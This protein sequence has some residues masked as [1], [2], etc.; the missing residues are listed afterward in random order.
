MTKEYKLYI[1]GEFRDALA[2]GKIAVR[3]PGT[4]EDFAEVA[5][6][7]REDARQ[8]VEAA[9][10]AYPGW[11]SLTVYEREGY[12]RKIAALMRERADSIGEALSREMGKPVAE[13]KGEV[14]GAAATIEWSAEVAK[15]YYGENIP[16]H[17]A[18]KRLVTLRSPV[19][20]TAAIAPWNF[21][22]MLMARKLGPALAVGCSMVG[23]SASQTP[24]S[25]MEFFGCVHDSGL[26]KGVANLVTGPPREQSGEFLENP[27]VRKI[28]FTGSVAVGKEIM[29]QGAGQM[30]RLSLELG[31]HSAFIVC[32]DADVKRAADIAV[33]GKFRNM[34]QSCIAPS[35]FFVPRDKQ[36]EFAEECA[37]LAGSLK[38]GYCME[39]GVEVGPLIDEVRRAATESLVGD[40]VKKGGTVLAGGKRPEGAA[41]EKGT[42]YLPTVVTGLTGDMLIMEEEPFAPI[43]PVIPYDD[44]DEA[45][46]KANSLPYGLA[47]YIA[48]RDIGHVFR[49]GE[50]LEAGV[51][52]VNDFA[53]ASPSAPFGGV[54]DSGMG[55]EGGWQVLDAYTETKFLSIVI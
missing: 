51:I 49:L 13:S 16:T 22:I 23:R 6:G 4:G 34:G 19:G 45:V 46:A 52:A 53:P 20:V 39:P 3:D 7:G 12:L 10:K 54:K 31:G 25:S 27:A 8:A 44:L 55:R 47:A 43:L 24:R 18:N 30:K 35:R 28:S 17:A 9:E 50:A 21:P 37:R 48:T 15:R 36:E 32:P 40:I 11:R 1:D 2:G 41:F 5:Y 38:L 33:Q 14:M 26:P 42:Y 29:R